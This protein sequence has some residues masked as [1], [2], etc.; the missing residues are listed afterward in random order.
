MIS[1]PLRV[2]G[3][4]LASREPS[5]GEAVP[6]QSIALALVA[7]VAGLIAVVAGIL[8]PF[9][10]VSTSTAS[11]TWPQHT[12]T[13]A[14]VTA[15][16]VAQTARSVD[17]SIPCRMLSTTP[18]DTSTVVLSTMPA[19]AA[20]ARDNGLFV[21]A[22]ANGVSV[23]N[24]NKTLAS[25][26]RDAL[27]GCTELRIF[28]D[29]TT[30]GAQFVGLPPGPAIAGGGAIGLAEP[31]SNP[32]ITGIFTEVVVAPA[33]DEEAIALFRQLAASGPRESRAWA[34]AH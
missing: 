14:S 24:R 26:P 20:K 29:S 31:A 28:S 10:P 5:S 4:V 16:L 15:P 8:T 33:A 22:D 27:A 1:R 34:Y 11:I 12:G 32:Q 21:V 6:R 25:V 7:A 2:L 3:V 9:L 18:A 19:A 30:T 23:T 13:S 17:I